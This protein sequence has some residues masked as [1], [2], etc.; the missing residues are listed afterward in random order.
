MRITLKVHLSQ[1][2]CSI[3]VVSKARRDRRVLECNPT[4]ETFR[5]HR[6][7]K[8]LRVTQVVFAESFGCD[9]CRDDQ[10]G[11]LSL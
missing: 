3:T 1:K 11:L 10:K 7:F 4:L 6:L 2:H 5:F 8:L 9:Y